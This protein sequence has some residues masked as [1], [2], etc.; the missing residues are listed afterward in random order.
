MLLAS[1]VSVSAKWAI[2][3]RYDTPRF[4]SQFD[5]LGAV[6]CRGHRYR[7]GLTS[8]LATNDFIRRGPVSGPVGRVTNGS[9]VRLFRPVR[10][11]GRNDGDMSASLHG[12]G[13]ATVK[14]ESGSLNRS[15]FPFSYADSS[16]V[17]L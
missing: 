13:G 17:S 14:H 10:P 11:C 3:P 5:F 16:D 8:E 2:P 15:L 4:P 7:E 9:F 6:G 12:V 1:E